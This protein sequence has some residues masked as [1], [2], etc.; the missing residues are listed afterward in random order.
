MTYR[1]NG[2][3]V[4][5]MKLKKAIKLIAYLTTLFAVNFLFQFLLSEV[6]VN[7]NYW[8]INLIAWLFYFLTIAIIALE[9]WRTA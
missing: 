3:K 5:I 9:A 1:V 8:F 6:L 2:E 7:N 4:D